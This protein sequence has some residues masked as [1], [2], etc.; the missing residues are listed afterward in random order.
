MNTI[1]AGIRKRFLQIILTIA[2]QG[3][4]LFIAASDLTWIAAWIYLILT[5]FLA[6]INTTYLIFKDPELIVE[7]S[8]VKTD[9]KSWDKPFALV[10][11]IIGPF[12]YLFVAGLDY[13]FDLSGRMPQGIQYCSGF[14]VIVGYF[15]WGWAM[16]A[17]RFFSGLVRIQKERGHTVAQG[18]PY[19]FVR[20]PG[21]VGMILFTIAIPLFLESF[22]ALIPA[23]LTIVAV[24]VRTWREDCTLKEEL[25]GY[26]AYTETVTA[27]LV[28]GLW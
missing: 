18:G 10:I 9:V 14:M 23:S 15:I 2:F 17:N 21:Y 27:R 28:P 12:I 5:T 7:R 13:R 11:S 26:L 20:H 3:I 16:A 4:I 1:S 25:D 22:W 6:V 19:R 24:I 8:E